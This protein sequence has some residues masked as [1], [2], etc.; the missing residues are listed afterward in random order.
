MVIIG[1]YFLKS[2]SI[3][4]SKISHAPPH[5]REIWDWLLLNANHSDTNI[6][7]RGQTIRTYK[8]IIE[9]QNCNPKVSDLY[10]A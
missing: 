4:K 2:R 8:D 9:I 10:S 1:G 5:I 3:Q 6:C 7:K